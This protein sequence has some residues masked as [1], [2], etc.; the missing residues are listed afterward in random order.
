MV[1]VQHVALLRRMQHVNSPNNEAAASR[2]WAQAVIC[3]AG[4]AMDGSMAEWFWG[5]AHV[6]LQA[7][8][9]TGSF[10]RHCRLLCGRCIVGMLALL[11]TSSV[12]SCF[13]RDWDVV[14]HCLVTS[15]SEPGRMC[16]AVVYRCWM[17]FRLRGGDIYK[18]PLALVRAR[19]PCFVHRFIRLVLCI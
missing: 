13:Q 18:W 10:T 8:R 19:Q 5:P 7:W 11:A 6:E 2:L 15:A 17:S 12:M 9:G 3:G 16:A 14:T 4:A 1:L